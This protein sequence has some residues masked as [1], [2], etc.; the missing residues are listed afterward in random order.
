DAI[1]LAHFSTS[2]AL[3]AVTAAVATPVLTAPDAA[4]DRIRAAIGG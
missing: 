1:M 2:R 3:A 4:V